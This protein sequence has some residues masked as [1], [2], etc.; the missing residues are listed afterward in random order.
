MSTEKEEKNEPTTPGVK[1]RKKEERVKAEEK[2]QADGV[3]RA[4][5]AP[6]TAPN[7]PQKAAEAKDKKKTGG[8][9]VV[10]PKAAEA[11]AKKK[12]A[13]EKKA[14][15]EALRKSKKQTTQ[16]PGQ[17]AAKK[18]K[19]APRRD[20]GSTP[21]M[22]FGDSDATMDDFAA[23]L[24]AGGGVAMP[25][26]RHFDVGD[27]VEGTVVS[28][29]ERYIVVDI[30]QPD[31]AMAERSQYENKEGELELEV[32]DTKTFFVVGFDDAVMLG[33]EIGSGGNALEAIETAHAS[34][35]PIS[36]K[37]TGTN[38]G[39]FEVNVGGV[40]AFCPI[41]QIELGYTED[42]QIHVGNTYQ[43][44]VSEVRE[45][46]RTVVLSRLSLLES[47]REAARK[48]TLERLEV[49]T[50]IDGVVTRVA[51]FGAFVDVGG[52]EGLVHVSEL[53]HTYFEKP[54]DV[55]SQGDNLTVKVLKIEEQDNGQLRIGLSAKEAQPDPWE[56]VNEKFAVGETVV[57]TVVRLATFGAF[58]E[59]FPGVEGLVHVSEM[60]RTKHVATPDQVV[61][62]GE[63]VQVEIQDIDLLRKR[64]SLSMAATEDDPWKTI[65]ERF[66]IGL[67]VTGTVANTEDFGAFIELS[68]GITA[69]LPR[70]EMNLP[71]EVSPHRKYQ[72]GQDVTARVLNI[73]PER[74]RMALTLREESEIDKSAAA[75]RKKKAAAKPS[76]PRSYT[77]EGFSGGGLG[78]L[79]D[80]LKA[81]EKDKKD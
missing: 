30:G 36:G 67:E 45:G 3:A 66:A 58:V 39:G 8:R 44:E 38:K 41:S 11:A 74:R 13:A 33:R 21:G 1:K 59:L 31:E 40:D 17:K 80:L 15:E 53:S 48:E 60:S 7:A 65:D 34:G 50:E 42:P 69:L 49:G 28:I 5:E 22:T 71:S 70:S 2:K 35:M 54:T 20:D 16:K 14:K 55:V 27:D 46:G 78:T 57:G 32:G 63:T 25:E 52:V 81:R 79:G 19:K 37:V 9:R 29:G 73:E 6:T 23:M 10:D 4:P 61:S 72:P 75:E 26:K 68:D 56:Q 64:I 18:A 76:G 47:Q 51:D 77:D 24:D 62:T 43:F 12:K